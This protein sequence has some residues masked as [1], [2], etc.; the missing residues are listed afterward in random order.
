MLKYLQEKKRYLWFVSK[1]RGV[2]QIG[3]RQGEWFMN[4]YTAHEG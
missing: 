1:Q 4:R 2:G 3:H